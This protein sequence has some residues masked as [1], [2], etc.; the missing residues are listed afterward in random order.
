MPLA[1]VGLSDL[2]AEG[3][4]AAADELT[5][6]ERVALATALGLK[7]AGRKQLDPIVL[8]RAFLGLLRVLARDAPVLVAIDDVQWLDSSSAGLVAFAA[9]RLGEEPIGLLVTRRADARDPLELDR[10]FQESRLEELHPAPLSLGAL[11]RLVRLRFDLHIP[12]PTLARV[13]AASGGNP[14]FALEFAR[15]LDRDRPQLGPI[16]IPASLKELVRARV[17]RC[18]DDIRHLLALVAAAER[19]TMS[20][21]EAVDPASPDLLVAAVGLEVVT[22]G[23]GE[24]VSFTHPLLGSAVYGGLPPPARR[25]LHAKLAQVSE[26]LEERARHRALAAAEPDGSVAALLD[27]AA[28]RAAAR[29]AR[30]AAAELAQEALRLTPPA[31]DE[32]RF[33]RILGAAGRLGEAGW[34]PEALALLDSHLAAGLEG[35]RRARALLLR[36]LLGD[37]VEEGRQLI[38]A[39]VPHVGDDAALRAELLLQLSSC[40]LYRGDLAASDASAL[41]A[42]AAADEAGDGPLRAAALMAVADRADLGGRPEPSLR[43]GAAALA[44][45][46]LL[47]SWYPSLR[48]SAGRRL[49]RRGD[50]KGAREA[51]ES[52]LAL[53]LERGAV[54]DRYRA[55]R[56]LSDV[57]RHAGRWE[58]SE[59]YIE[60]AS[61]YAAVRGDR[62][63]EAELLQRQ[64][65]L[66]AVRG[67]VDEARELVAQGIAQAEAINWPHLAA[68]NRWTLGTLELS[69]DEPVLAWQAL[70][71]VRSTA[72]WGRLEAIEALA[73]AVEALVG[74][75]R[76]DAAAELLGTLEQDRDRGGPWA[77]SAYLRCWAL[78]LLARRSLQQACAVAEQAAAGFERAGFRLHAGRALLV[79]GKALRRSG[80]RRRAGDVLDAA[81]AIFLDLGAERWADRS[82]DESRRAR[83]RP[84]RD[85]ELTHAER[86]VAAL[87]ALGKKNREV[88]A[89][90]FTTVATVEAHLTRI[91]RKLGIR[92]RTEL[93]RLVADGRVFLD[94]D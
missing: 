48:E 58:L 63:G 11:A 20:L 32:Q 77:G 22:V 67:R 7:P 79:A 6:H 4:P 41:E 52:E 88:A 66:A 8:P 80:E 36:I 93:A 27:A 71:D 12:R 46:A 21:L 13:R 45:D 30:E 85:R 38:E 57:E 76:L 49:L 44:D 64:A 84:R 69:L 40:H 62:W 24:L 17:E 31:D 43:E 75:G 9:R 87:V 28:A 29:G 23:D 19:P 47:P 1:F 2:F 72:T 94:D 10:A 65:A 89:Q 15:S 54:P 92:S 78:L 18:P 90:L 82:N 33:E 42:L 53:A 35:S 91:Y 25:S 56:E 14:M 50:L 5:E 34:F 3:L 16:A 59:R 83:P 37:D 55:L 74:A 81:R 26:D 86:R 61:E 39:A 73:D 51:L 68:M 70:E 60:D